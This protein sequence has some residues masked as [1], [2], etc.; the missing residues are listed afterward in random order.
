MTTTAKLFITICCAIVVLD[1][2]ANGC[3]Q[4]VNNELECLRNN[5]SSCYVNDYER[6]SE[7]LDRAEKKARRCKTSRDMA[8]FLMLIDVRSSNA[9]FNE[10][11][12][13]IIEELCIA[14]AKCFVAS[15]KL[16]PV[17][18]RNELIHRLQNPVFY[19]EEVLQ[20]GCLGSLKKIYFK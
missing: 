11:I 9:E 15:A 7:I 19:E 18:T 14:K 6:F 10:Y 17:P 8:N 4:G 3:C 13:E 16:L 5:V 1:A 20:Q 12:H 2:Q